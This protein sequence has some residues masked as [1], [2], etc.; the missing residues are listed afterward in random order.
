MFRPVSQ[1]GYG[2]NKSTFFWSRDANHVLENCYF[3]G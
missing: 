1:G 3:G 2:I